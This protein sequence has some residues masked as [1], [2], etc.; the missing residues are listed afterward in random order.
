MTPILLTERIGSV[1][2]T[3]F[4]S[5]FISGLIVRLF[6]ANSRS[7]IGFDDGSRCGRRLLITPKQDQPILSLAEEK[8][9]V[10]ARDDH[11]SSNICPLRLPMLNTYRLSHTYICRGKW[12]S[13]AHMCHKQMNQRFDDHSKKDPENQEERRPKARVT[14]IQHRVKCLSFTSIKQ[15]ITCPEPMRTVFVRQIAPHLSLL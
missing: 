10:T 1:G 6:M 4:R 5:P 9:F 12:K 11:L 8:I 2:N 14:S 3:V 13:M 7:N 15:T